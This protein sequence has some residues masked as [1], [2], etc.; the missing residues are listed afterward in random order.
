M[1]RK[2]LNPRPNLYNNRNNKLKSLLK[3]N[4][5]RLRNQ[6]KEFGL[7]RSWIMMQV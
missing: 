4:L 3:R 5:K 1:P 7:Q 2:E 6:R